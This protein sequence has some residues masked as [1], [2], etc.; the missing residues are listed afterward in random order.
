MVSS[1]R[2]PLWKS[3]RINSEFWWNVATDGHP[4]PFKSDER[5]WLVIQN[6]NETLKKKIPKNKQI[7]FLFIFSLTWNYNV[8]IALWF[9][10]SLWFINSTNSPLWMH[11]SSYK[12]KCILLEI[13]IS[14]QTYLGPRYLIHTKLAQSWSKFCPK[15][16]PIHSELNNMLLNFFVSLVNIGPKLKWVFYRYDC[17]YVCI[18]L[19]PLH[20]KYVQENYSE[21]TVKKV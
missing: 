8:I 18:L 17:M 9:A 15:P 7:L 20:C 21:I 6:L 2:I 4:F 16:K 19:F 11:L 1:R 14:Y 10:I 5:Y 13:V 3:H 12:I